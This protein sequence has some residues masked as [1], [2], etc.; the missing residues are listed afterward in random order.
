[1]SVLLE[2]NLIERAWFIENKIKS[3]LKGKGIVEVRGKGAMLGLELESRELTQLVVEAA[4]EK[5]ILL[6]WTL[7]SNTLIRL[8]PALTMPEDVLDEVLEVILDLIKQ[9]QNN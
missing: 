9:F 7:H 1:L 3:K 5:N 6:G 2:E 4:M 8:A